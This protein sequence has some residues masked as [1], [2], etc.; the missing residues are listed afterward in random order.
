MK[1]FLLLVLRRSLL[2]AI[3]MAGVYTMFMECMN[4]QIMIITIT[5]LMLFTL[6]LGAVETYL[7]TYLNIRNKIMFFAFIS[8]MSDFK[9]YMWGLYYDLNLVKLPLQVY[10]TA[11]VGKSFDV[12]EERYRLLF[13]IL[14]FIIHM[15][16]NWKN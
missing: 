13:I 6:I 15:K 2:L 12:W 1:T 8:F 9:N 5:N 10:R 4:S 16:L 7:Y 3:T 11:C 14:A